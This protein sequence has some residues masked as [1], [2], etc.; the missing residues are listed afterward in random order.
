MKDSIRLSKEH[1]VNPSMSIC[2][3]CGETKELLLLGKLKNDE[4]APRKMM[5]DYEPCE[6]CKEKFSRGILIIE[7]IEEPKYEGQPE[8]TKNVYPSGPHWVV[9]KQVIQKLIADKDL[10]ED[11]IEKRAM[12]VTKETAEEIGLYQQFYDGEANNE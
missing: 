12:F 8:I 7:A 3:Y 1:G 6:D 5:I 2:F 10:V 9:K 11:I 4:E